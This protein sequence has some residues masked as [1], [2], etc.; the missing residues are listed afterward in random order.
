MGAVNL[1]D[2]IL[3]TA[4]FDVHQVRLVQV[5]AGDGS[6]EDIL[7][8]YVLSDDDDDNGAAAAEARPKQPQ[9]RQSGKKAPAGKPSKERKA[10]KGKGGSLGVLKG[11]Q[12]FKKSKHRQR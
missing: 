6:D 11:S 3:C 2:V 9:H 8:D 1:T 5:D 4:E 10:G 7:E 12:K